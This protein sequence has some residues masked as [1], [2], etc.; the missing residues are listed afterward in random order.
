MRQI[1]PRQ[2]TLFVTRVAVL[3]ALAVV[4][5]FI[6][7]QIWM[8][9][10]RGFPLVLSG[11]VLGPVGGAYVGA[12][13]DIVGVYL[14]PTGQ[15][16]PIYTFTAML[17]AIV[18]VALISLWRRR[19]LPGYL[20]LLVAILCGQ[21]LTKALIQPVFLELVTR[22][23]WTVGAAKGAIE[24]LVHAPLYAALS[25]AVIRALPPRLVYFPNPP[26]QETAMPSPGL[27]MPLR[28]PYS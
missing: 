19:G 28:R 21:L 5:K 1:G 8:F 9:S 17:T 4:T 10:L 23:P 18:P 20:E 13:S 12:L 11:F 26:R 24:E 2:A 7:P 27:A 6:T 16:N 14:L 3:A 15:F 25:L 22:V